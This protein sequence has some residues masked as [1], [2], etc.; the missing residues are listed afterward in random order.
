MKSVFKIEKHLFVKAGSRYTI[1]FKITEIWQESIA[2]AHQTFSVPKFWELLEL[3]Q[4]SL[5]S[6]Y[7]P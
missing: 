7:G 4:S 3:L 5:I 6:H 2:I 1:Y